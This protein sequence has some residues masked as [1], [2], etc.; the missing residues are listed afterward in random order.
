MLLRT[1]H[2]LAVSASLDLHVRRE[3]IESERCDDRRHADEVELWLN[4]LVGDCEEHHA[5]DLSSTMD[6]CE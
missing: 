1:L 5:A 6:N 2:S 3:S 4:L